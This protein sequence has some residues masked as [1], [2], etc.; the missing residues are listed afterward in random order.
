[1][2][3]TELNGGSAAS[4]RRDFTPRDF[5]DAMGQF[6]TGVVI[7]STEN[8]GV[9]HAM[10][11]NAFM[12]GS[13]DPF[14]VLVS[15]AKTARMHGRLRSA[16]H[17]GISIL[18]QAQQWISNHFAGKPTPD[19]EPRFE[20]L[21]GAP[22]IHG[23]MMRLAA[24]LHAEHPCGDHTLFVGQVRAL[25][26]DRDAGKPLLYYGGRYRRVAPTDWTAETMLQIL[27]QE[28]DLRY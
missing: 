4:G 25:E 7:I 8:D 13:I 27:W 6:T 9:V 16:G 21:D 12:S 20:D 3:Q 17:Y 10:T 5:R 24:D 23:A 28:N 1:M 14:L 15:V 19:R 18:G 22:V 26:L 2:T 11:A